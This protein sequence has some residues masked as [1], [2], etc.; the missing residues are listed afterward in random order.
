MDGYT[1]HL[2]GLLLSH[3]R[4]AAHGLHIWPFADALGGPSVHVTVRELEA[5]H[6]FRAETLEE[7]IRDALTELGIEVPER[8]SV[9]RARGA[10]KWATFSHEA[11]LV[12]ARDDVVEFLRGLYA[13]EPLTVL[14][15][16]EGEA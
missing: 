13:I 11:E 14:A 10:R 8:P 2:L 16:L 5:P 3:E 1:M 6:D 4:A 7:A 12:D 15:I 9:E